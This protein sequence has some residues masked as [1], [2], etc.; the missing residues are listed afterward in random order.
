[1]PIY[2]YYCKNCTEES[3][4]TLHQVDDRGNEVCP[5][6]GGKA[7]IDISVNIAVIPPMDMVLNDLRPDGPVH[8][9]S[10]AQLKAECALQ[11]CEL[12]HVRKAKA[13]KE[14]FLCH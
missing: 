4:E 12:S 1:M 13:K 10:R 6:C 11:G 2:K 14:V 9:T 3:W 7:N 5:K 8:I